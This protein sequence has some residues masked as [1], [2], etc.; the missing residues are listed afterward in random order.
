MLKR[1]IGSNMNRIWRTAFLLSLLQSDVV[2][3][4]FCEHCLSLDSDDV[5]QNVALLLGV[6]ILVGGLIFIFFSTASQPAEP[7]LSFGL[8]VKQAKEKVESMS[9]HD[10]NPRRTRATGVIRAPADGMYEAQYTNGFW[11]A[12]LSVDLN[13]TK[14]KLGWTIRGNG[15]RPDGRFVIVSGFVTH[16][17][18]A[19]WLERQPPG[20][21]I[22]VHGTFDLRHPNKTTLTEGHWRN[23]LGKTGEFIHFRFAGGDDSV[24]E[25]TTTGSASTDSEES[26]ADD[27]EQQDFRL[28]Q[29]EEEDRPRSKGVRNGRRDEEDG[30]T[31]PKG[32]SIDEADRSRP[33]GN[34]DGRRQSK[35][36]YS[37]PLEVPNEW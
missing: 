18:S 5:S 21:E 32:R 13:F 28:L 22:L 10:P 25:T 2:A 33:K 36:T 37:P 17:G 16:G 4:S 20:R 19:Y 31:M 35:P 34:R 7:K 27:L 23:A 11:K 1:A 9:S 12:R 30:R 26:Y 15:K 8:H 6:V 3:R 29:D 24:G 14:S